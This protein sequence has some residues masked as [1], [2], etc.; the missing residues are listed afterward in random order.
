MLRRMIVPGTVRDDRE[1]WKQCL[2]FVQREAKAPWRGH[3][4]L[5][6]EA[7]PMLGQL[8]VA[9]RK[10]FLVIHWTL[11][12]T[13]AVWC[14][15]SGFYQ[16][17]LRVGLWDPESS[18]T[19]RCIYQAACDRHIDSDLSRAVL[20]HSTNRFVCTYCVLHDSS[21]NKKRVH[22]LISITNTSSAPGCLKPFLVNE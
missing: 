13:E 8:G 11:C 18:F 14:S 17:R 12:Q 1:K 10:R 20:R 2:Q 15:K 4:L 5:S 19:E 6:S 9:R 7:S 16:C 22:V 21:S 3:G